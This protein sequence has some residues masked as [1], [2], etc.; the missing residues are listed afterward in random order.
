[1]HE[2]TTKN[3][4]ICSI[5]NKLYASKESLKKHSQRKHVLD[6]SKNFQKCTM[7]GKNQSKANFARHLKRCS[8]TNRCPFCLKIFKSNGLGKHRAT[9]KNNKTN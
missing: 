9:C 4:L 5:C 2:N 1:M 8:N 7:C 3:F 6:T